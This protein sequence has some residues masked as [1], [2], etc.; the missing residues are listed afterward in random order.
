[1]FY[2]FFWIS[3]RL[4]MC[5]HLSDVFQIASSA[6]FINQASQN[7]PTKRLVDGEKES[8]LVQKETIYRQ[9]TSWVPAPETKYS[10]KKNTRFLQLWSYV[11][12]IW[13]GAW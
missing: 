11:Y 12:I 2:S 4:K 7:I 6:A 13:G 8:R 3:F 10:Y 5:L 1:M 9:T